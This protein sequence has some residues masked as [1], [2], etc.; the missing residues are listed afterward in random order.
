MERIVLIKPLVPKILPLFPPTGL[1]YLAAVLEKKG[2]K[3]YIIDCSMLNITYDRLIKF[4]IKINPL[5]VGITALTV[6]YSE[7]KTLSR[8]IKTTDELKNIPVVL[9]G[10]HVSFLPEICIKECD[11]DYVVMGEGEI[12]LLELAEALKNNSHINVEV[13]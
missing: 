5:L 13:S 2:Y 8:L 9:G 10:V 1:A 7:M 11:A 3:V 12:T 6:N 4:L